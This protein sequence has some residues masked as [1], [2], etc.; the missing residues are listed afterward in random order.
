MYCHVY[1]CGAR[2]QPPRS[3]AGRERGRHAHA[4]LGVAAVEGIRSD[5]NLHRQLQAASEHRGP[6]GEV[7][8]RRTDNTRSL[9]DGMRVCDDYLLLRPPKFKCDWLQRRQ[10][11]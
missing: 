10:H 7:G 1:G 11:Q 9:G 8:L 2:A 6:P 5:P 4:C 3:A